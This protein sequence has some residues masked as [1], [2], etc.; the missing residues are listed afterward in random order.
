[1]SLKTTAL[2]N[3]HKRLDATFGSFGG[4]YMPIYYSGIIDEHNWTRNQVSVFDISHMGEL[5]ISGRQVKDALDKIVTV[6]LD[7]M[8]AGACRYG[9][10]LNEKGGII[11]DLIIYMIN[12]NKWMAVVNAATAQKDILHFK[13]YLPEDV[14]L[15]DISDKTGKI[16]IQGPKSK[17]VLSSIVS[18]NLKELKYYTFSYFDILGE[19]NIISR[20]GYT[21]EL[22]YEAYISIDNIKELW[23]RLLKDKRVRPAG[24]GARDTLRLEM[25]YPLYGQDI[26][27]GSIPAEAGLEQFVDF[28]KE[29]IG[30]EA[31]LKKKEK[32][33]ARRLVCFKAKSR[34]SPR[35]NYAIWKDSNQIGTVTSGTFS[36]SLSCGIGMGYIKQEYNNIAESIIIKSNNMSLEAEIT[37]KPFF[38]KGSAKY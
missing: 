26:T 16:D 17:K 7:N 9:F 23:R 1:M 20:T 34:R 36:P 24:L 21:G 29:F 28:D 4:W 30:K 11:D 27:E 32:P 31:L 15:E 8:K 18:G 13:N 2:I 5:I 3:E 12:E 37:Q 6:N 10:I 19:E 14:N 35:H 25:A 33:I 38:K 22:G